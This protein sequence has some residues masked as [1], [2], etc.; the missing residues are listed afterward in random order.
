MRPPCQSQMVNEIVIFRIEQVGSLCI[1]GEYA[2]APTETGIQQPIGSISGVRGI[3]AAVP[4]C[5]H[6][7]GEP[8]ADIDSALYG[9]LV[10]HVVESVF[11]DMVGSGFG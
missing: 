8:L 3:V 1:D 5:R 9:G 4:R 10:F 7:G 11:G 6:F 2:P